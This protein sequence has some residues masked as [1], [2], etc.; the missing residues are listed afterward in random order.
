M[1]PHPSQYEIPY[2]FPTFS[3][4]DDPHSLPILHEIVW[5]LFTCREYFEMLDMVFCQFSSVYGQMYH[6]LLNINEFELYIFHTFENMKFSTFSW[7]FDPFPNLCWLCQPIPYL[8]KALKYWNLIPD[9]L[10]TFPTCENPVYRNLWQWHHRFFQAKHVNINMI[11]VIP[12][13]NSSE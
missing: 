10:K 7:L 1:F 9:L 11:G 4:L 3:W 13:T 6:F 12:Y 8:S 5:N 2:L